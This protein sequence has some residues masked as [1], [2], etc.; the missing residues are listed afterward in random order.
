MCVIMNPENKKYKV[1][2]ER[3]LAAAKECSTAARVLKTIFPKAF[4]KSSPRL[5]KLG[6]VWKFKHNDDEEFLLITKS[7]GEDY[8]YGGYC[9]FSLTEYY[10]NNPTRITEACLTEG[11]VTF[12]A[13]NLHHAVVR[14]KGDGNA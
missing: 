10:L 9:C 13:E 3:I 8:T 6:E 11:K 4:A 14:I 1:T 2:H 7:A 5:P 12:F